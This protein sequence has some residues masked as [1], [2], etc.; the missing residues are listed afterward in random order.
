MR[1]N[2]ATIIKNASVTSSHSDQ[3]RL[4]SRSCCES[5][6]DHKLVAHGPGNY[7]HS[8]SFPERHHAAVDNGSLLDVYGELGRHISFSNQPTKARLCS[9]TSNISLQASV[10]P[11][12]LLSRLWFMAPEYNRRAGGDRYL[13]GYQYHI[14]RSLWVLEEASSELL[15]LT[16][17]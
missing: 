1:V 2:P 9:K 11:P 7:Y 16:D 15:H 12:S 4:C 8:L 6:L 10:T 17:F 14:R 5:H 3:L 13:P